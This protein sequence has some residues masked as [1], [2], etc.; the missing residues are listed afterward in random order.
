MRS[1]GHLR[2][3]PPL[4]DTACIRGRVKSWR[5]S[6]PLIEITWLWAAIAGGR[7]YEG[8]M[9]RFGAPPLRH[10]FEFAGVEFIDENDGRLV[11]WLR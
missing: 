3:H 8:Q 11:V 5:R 2:G 7:G 10:A 4:D 9:G 6:K 1:H